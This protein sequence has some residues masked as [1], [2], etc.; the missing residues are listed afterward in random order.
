[1]HIAN[2]MMAASHL[3]MPPFLVKWMSEG[4]KL[5][6]TEEQAVRAKHLIKRLVG[7]SYI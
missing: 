5:D 4:S 6:C 1:M 7:S 3:I 2:I